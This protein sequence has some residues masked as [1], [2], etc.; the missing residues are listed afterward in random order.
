MNQS[1]T[2]VTCGYEFEFDRLKFPLCFSQCDLTAVCELWRSTETSAF[3]PYVDS[4]LT[5]KSTHWLL[6][7][8]ISFH[9][10]FTK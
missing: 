2:V 3:S 8:N 7:Q 4:I 1:A 10:R 5:F 6:V 9:L